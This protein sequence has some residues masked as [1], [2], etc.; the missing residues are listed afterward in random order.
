MTRFVNWYLQL[1][2]LYNVLSINDTHVDHVRY[3]N[4][5]Q[6]AFDFT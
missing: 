2:Q 5:T 1:F 3:A 4:S 6:M